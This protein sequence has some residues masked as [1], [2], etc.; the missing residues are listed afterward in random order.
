VAA[1]KSVIEQALF[2]QSLLHGEEWRHQAEA[3]SHCQ[4]I[5][6]QEPSVEIIHA[7]KSA[8]IIYFS[9]RSNGV[10]EELRLK[11][12]EIMR[13][14]SDYLEGTY[15]LHGIE[16]VMQKNETLVL[17]EPFKDEIKKYQEALSD[18]IGLNVIAISSFDTPFP[19][20][21]IPKLQGYDTYFQLMAGW[22]ML[23]AAGIANG[24][25]LDKPVRARKIGNEI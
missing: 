10:A 6:A 1:T 12:N 3:A 9:G 13:C 8:P 18:K 14:K 19:T 17:I 15:A 20:F 11:T 25:N 5:L 2:Y 24:I 16:E 7:L 22:N 23:V 4:D 21:S